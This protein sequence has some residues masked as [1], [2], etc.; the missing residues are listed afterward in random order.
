MVALNWCGSE[1]KIFGNTHTSDPN[2]TW[3]NRTCTLSIS[4][5][6]KM[7]TIFQYTET[8]PVNLKSTIIKDFAQV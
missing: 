6:T 3:A 2:P 7:Q 1:D 5:T 8:L 4:Q